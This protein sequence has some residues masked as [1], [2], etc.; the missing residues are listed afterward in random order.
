MPSRFAAVILDLKPLPPADASWQA[1]VETIKAEFSD[2]PT[3][4]QL[5]DVYTTLRREKERVDALLSIVNIR[6]EAVMQLLDA[7][8]EAGVDGWGQYGVGDNAVR[9]ANGDTLRVDRKPYGQVKDKEAF[10]LWCVANGYEG[11]MQ[12]WP[13]TM[14]T[15]VKE[16]VLSGD[17]LPDGT[18]VFSKAT[19]VYTPAKEKA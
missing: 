9:L 11:Q 8:Q 7:S 13:T 18:D 1:R 19:I 4:A 5:V 6:L 15:I 2:A 16:R 14:N 12:L 17:A 10:R 3:T